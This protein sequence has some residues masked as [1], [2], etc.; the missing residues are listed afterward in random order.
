MSIGCH[1]DL[2]FYVKMQ[3]HP[4]IDSAEA[5]KDFEMISKIPCINLGKAEEGL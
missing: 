1:Q 3:K 2:D 5:L 4:Q